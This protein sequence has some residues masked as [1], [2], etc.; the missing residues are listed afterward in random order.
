[1]L[2]SGDYVAVR[3]SVGKPKWD[4]GYALNCEIKA[5]MPFGLRDISK[6]EFTEKYRQRLENT[7][8]D[9][10]AQGFAAIRNRFPNKDIV[11]LCYEDIR[12]GDKWCHRTMFA[13]WWFDKT[14]VSIDELPD[15]SKTAS[16]PSQDDISQS[17]QSN[18]TT[19]TEQL[20]M[21]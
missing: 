17:E 16:K 20:T 4:L 8:T 13:D 11:L 10:F 5:L 9:N 21:F 15:D 14:G 3:I 7:G 18:T 12:N 1:M 6:A 2:R 19:H